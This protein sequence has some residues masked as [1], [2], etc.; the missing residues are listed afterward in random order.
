[1]K[2]VKPIGRTSSATTIQGYVKDHR[3][4]TLE[5]LEKADNPFEFMNILGQHEG[6]IISMLPLDGKTLDEVTSECE[7]FRRMTFSKYK[8]MWETIH[9]LLDLLDVWKMADQKFSG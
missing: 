5:R 6:V 9:G 8:E 2:S 7:S 3:E 4:F 1:M